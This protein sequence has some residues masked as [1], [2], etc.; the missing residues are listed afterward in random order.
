MKLCTHCGGQISDTAKFC[1][2]CGNKVI[3]QMKVCTGCGGKLKPT[4]K[5]C[6][7]CG[8]QV[9]I[10][11]PT[12]SPTAE[13]K[14]ESADRPLQ[15]NEPE[16]RQES[17]PRPI[18]KMPRKPEM[19]PMPEEVPVFRNQKNSAQEEVPVFRGPQN[20]VQKEAPVFRGPQNIAQEEVPVFRGPQ[21]TAQEEM[22]IFQGPQSTAQEEMPIFRGPQ[23]VT[24]EE[25]PAFRAP[26]QLDSSMSE[27]HNMNNAKQ[28]N[29]KGFSSPQK[30][31]PTFTA[32]DNSWEPEG[33]VC[34]Y[35]ETE[36]AVTNCARCGAPLCE[37][38]AESYGF[39]DGKYA[40]QILCYDC[41]SQIV[42]EDIDRLNN[43]YSSIK[44][45]F[46]FFMI[47]VIVG[48]LFG[49]AMGIENGILSALVD[50]LIM[51]AIGGS[52][53]TF[54][55]RFLSAVPGFF[56]PSGNIMISVAIGIG[57]FLFYFC[58]YALM[59][60]F[61]T[62]KK[63]IHYITYMKKTNG[64]IQYDTDALARMRDY[65]EYTQVRN[66]NRNLDLQTLLK[67]QSQLQGNSYA[68]TVMQQGEA[69]AEATIH[70]Y[71]TRIAENG[72]IIREFAA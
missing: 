22:P 61:D 50:F 27:I 65:M 47:G 26:Q 5:F 48:G 9:D 29:P 68:Q 4:S 24:Q 53:A 7:M 32:P 56:V 23:N 16:V 28:F 18:Y 72:E 46:M 44:Q 1:P 25:I 10:I 13:M 58:L 20:I 8:M 70:Q 51:A 54:I 21:N 60:I 55:K 64:I 6:P 45:Q 57:K 3:S 59:A 15:K 33:P 14:F 42:Q 12:A 52:F 41:T 36:P 17:K 71:I 62:T 37:D 38:C 66:R 19:N 2:H 49:L 43:N 35:H 31:M 30:E 40:G 34:T 67:Q 69:Q 63:L 39:T 11:Q